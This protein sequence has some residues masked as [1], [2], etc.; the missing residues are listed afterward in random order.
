MGSD[1][2]AGKVAGTDS[3]SM[4]E[5]VGGDMAGQSET[6]DGRGRQDH[7][8]ATI[9]GAVEEKGVA[10]KGHDPSRQEDQSVTILVDSQKDAVE[11][12]RAEAKVVG[13]VEVE[14]QERSEETRAGDTTVEGEDGPPHDG[15]VEHTAENSREKETPTQREEEGSMAF[16]EGESENKD[17]QMK[18]MAMVAVLPNEVS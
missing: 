4:E 11:G 2:P 1:A 6:G 12:G 17:D 14:Q 16:S 9:G 13:K 5:S 10:S 7:V 15:V 8:L 18:L 3:L